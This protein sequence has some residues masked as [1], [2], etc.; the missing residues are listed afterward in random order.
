MHLEPDTLQH[1]D[2]ASL[3]AAGIARRLFAIIYD[4]LLLAAISLAYAI[5]VWLMRSI[6]E[7]SLHGHG[8]VT[9]VASGVIMLGWWLALASYFCWCWHKRGQTLAMKTWRL[10]LQQLNGALPTAR[11]C[12]LRAVIAPLSLLSTVGLLWL[13]FDPNGDALHDRLTATRVVLLPKKTN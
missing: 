7:G 4:L 6:P 5:V 13:L 12:W 9:G 11:Q 8:S 2:V 10:R 3:P 1:I